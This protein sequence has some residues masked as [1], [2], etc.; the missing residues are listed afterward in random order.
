MIATVVLDPGN[1]SKAEPF[2]R[3]FREHRWESL[4]AF[5]KWKA[6]NDNLE[7]Y[8]IRCE[9]GCALL[10]VYS[11]FELLHC[12]CVFHCEPLSVEEGL[13]L[14]S[15]VPEKNWQSLTE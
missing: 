13:S 2:C 7:A 14:E 10:V 15:L 11:H 4:K 3:A 12:D 1:K 6:T 9:T 8:A 5:Q